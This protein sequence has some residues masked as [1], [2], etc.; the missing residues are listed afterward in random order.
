MANKCRVDMG[1]SFSIKM[2]LLKTFTEL[3]YKQAH[4]SIF[5]SF[6]MISYESVNIEHLNLFKR[7]NL[8]VLSINTVKSTCWN[9]KMKPEDI[10]FYMQGPLFR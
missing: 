8:C 5:Y 2:E 3:F 6:C 10:F 9:F 4:I 7:S 1:F